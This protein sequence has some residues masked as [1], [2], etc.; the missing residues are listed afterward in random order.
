MSVEERCRQEVQGIQTCGSFRDARNRDN[1]VRHSAAEKRIDEGEE[2]GPPISAVG[3]SPTAGTAGR[4]GTGCTPERGQA[5]GR[6]R[7][8]G[9]CATAILLRWAL[10]LKPVLGQL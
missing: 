2:Q 1:V 9:P 7:A 5:W 8:A 10:Q 4:L 3:R 6:A